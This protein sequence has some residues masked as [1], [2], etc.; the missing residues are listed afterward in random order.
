ME[1]GGAAI[2][3]AQAEA[4]AEGKATASPDADQKKPDGAKADASDSETSGEDDS[5]GTSDSS[6]DVEAGS[7][8]KKN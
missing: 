4:P 8:P 3:A 1:C 5:P 7:P 2:F 6:S